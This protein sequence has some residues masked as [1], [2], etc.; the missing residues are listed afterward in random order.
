MQ[1]RSAKDLIVYQ[2]DKETHRRLV[3]LC[4]EVGKMLGAMLNNPKPFP[5]TAEV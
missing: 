4:A 3:A 2:M 1:I 5:L